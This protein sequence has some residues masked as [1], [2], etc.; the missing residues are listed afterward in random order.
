MKF[1]KIVMNHPPNNVF[2]SLTH[3][4]TGSSSKKS[5]KSVTAVII[6]VSGALSSSSRRSRAGQPRLSGVSLPRFRHFFGG[7]VF[8]FFPCLCWWLSLYP[9]VAA[10]MPSSGNRTPHGAQHPRVGVWGSPLAAGTGGRAKHTTTE[11]T[12][13]MFCL[14]FKISRSL[15]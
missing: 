10:P 8:F 14:N 5:N 6:V 12:R 2:H 15:M 3:T 1:L 7:V 13:K 11:R 4:H 9:A